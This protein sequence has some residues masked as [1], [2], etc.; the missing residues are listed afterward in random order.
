VP[1]TSRVGSADS[2]TATTL[3]VI[4]FVFVAADTN[5]VRGDTEE[6]CR[7]EDRADAGRPHRRHVTAVTPH[8]HRRQGS[9]AS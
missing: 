8:R 5:V 9:G 6:W 2:G 3:G 7:G 4:G 1:S